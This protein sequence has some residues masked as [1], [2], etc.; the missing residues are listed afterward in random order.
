VQHSLVVAVAAAA[1]G[2]TESKSNIREQFIGKYIAKAEQTWNKF[3]GF[4]GAAT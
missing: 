2:P 3:W 4:W 1:A